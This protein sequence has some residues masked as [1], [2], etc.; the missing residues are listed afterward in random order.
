MPFVELDENFEPAKGGESA[1]PNFEEIRVHPVEGRPRGL[2]RRYGKRALEIALILIAALPIIMVVL[3]LA[4]A[5]AHD[6]G[7][8]FYSQMRVGRHG[9]LYRMWKLRSMVPGA[10][11]MLEA[12]LAE[13]PRARAEWDATQKLRNDPRVTPVGQLLRKTSLDELPQLWNVVC[14]E[15]SLVGPRPMLNEQRV[16]YPGRDYYALK[17][18]I[19]GSGRSLRATRANS[20]S[21][22]ASIPSTTGS[23]RSGR[24]CGSLWPR[25]AWFAAAR[26]T[27]PGDDTKPSGDGEAAISPDSARIA[28][29]CVSFCPA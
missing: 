20:R 27:E 22:P 13:S 26:G 28:S 17:P 29:R 12:H 7:G 11:A 14:G 19:T 21:A 10:E 18:G 8:A 2:Y 15:M 23:F 4:V 24:T 16:L 5:V 6:G 1:L 25:S 9:R 3:P